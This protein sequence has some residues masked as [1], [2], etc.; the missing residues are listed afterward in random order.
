[1]EAGRLWVQAQVKTHE[2]LIFALIVFF[3]MDL[4]NN[5]LSISSTVP[6]PHVSPCNIPQ[7]TSQTCTTQTHTYA[8]NQAIV[9]WWNNSSHARDIEYPTTN[10]IAI[11]T[12]LI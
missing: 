3:H 10:A 9:K 7:L 6:S 4:P 8:T 11:T 2:K 1:M 12:N 5:I